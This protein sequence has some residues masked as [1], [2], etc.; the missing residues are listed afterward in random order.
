MGYIDVIY[1]GQCLRR[2]PVLSPVHASTGE[3]KVN[4]GRESIP[5]RC[6]RGAG[7]REDAVRTWH[8]DDA[9][10]LPPTDGGDA[11]SLPIR[12]EPIL[13]EARRGAVGRSNEHGRS[14]YLERW[15]IRSRSASRLRNYSATRSGPPTNPVP[16]FGVEEIVAHLVPAR[17]STTTAVMRRGDGRGLACIGSRITPRT[18]GPIVVSHQG[19]LMQR[20]EELEHRGI[21]IAREAYACV[22][23]QRCCGRCARTPPS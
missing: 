6:D 2:I 4:C 21:Y 8:R 7:V 5:Q 15:Q 14:T 18:Q 13:Q 1:H 23:S 11:P 20:M 10:V 16:A 3:T 12:T 9:W 17:K 22:Q 19:N